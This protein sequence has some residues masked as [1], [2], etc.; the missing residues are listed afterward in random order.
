MG[1]RTLEDRLRA[2][3]K[4]LESRGCPVRL[5]PLEAFKQIH[6]PVLDRNTRTG[7]FDPITRWFIATHGP[8]V[9]WDGVIGR[10][11][12][13]IRGTVY[14]LRLKF[15]EETNVV[16]LAEQIEDIPEEIA[17]SLSASE[18]RDTAD[19]GTA[20]WLA[21]GPLYNLGIDDHILSSV[22][23]ELFWRATEDLKVAALSLKQLESAQIAIFHAHEA[24]EKMLKIAFRRL[25]PGIAVEKYQH[26]VNKLFD[27]LQKVT[28][29]LNWLGKSVK[30]LDTQM[31]NMQIRYREL[32]RT[33][34][35]AVVSFNAASY[36][37]GS[38]ACIWLFDDKRKGRQAKF[39]AGT[40]YTDSQDQIWHCKGLFA[41][42][43]SVCLTQLGNRPDG[44]LLMFDRISPV[45]IAPLFLE[46]IDSA[47]V[48]RLRAL[49]QFYAKVCDRRIEPSDIGMKVHSDSQGAFATGI[50]RTKLNRHPSKPD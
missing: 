39:Y 16:P 23:R 36:I 7:L 46:V 37:A 5:R 2:I 40:F 6:G 9:E 33:I 34:Q 42:G 3:D 25:L 8:Q 18:F 27:D 20:G 41:S 12:V 38:L 1:K 43:R 21:F 10:V 11:P 17:K 24:A 47:E 4:D 32:R 48:Q 15:Q 22:D 45:E 30:E 29:D 44:G 26:N 13:I 14:L 50:F 49:K 35:E 28:P 31:P 19:R